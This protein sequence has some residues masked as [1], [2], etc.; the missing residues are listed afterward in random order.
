M[1]LNQVLGYKNPFW[2]YLLGSFVVIIF[3]VIG[4][5]P[6]TFF[7]TSESISASGGDPIAALRNLDKNLQLLLLLVPFAVGF[8]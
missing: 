7:I 5:L 6:L 8:L 1:F 3:T 4:Q 2:M